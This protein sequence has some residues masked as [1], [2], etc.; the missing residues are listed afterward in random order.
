MLILNQWKVIVLFLYNHFFYCSVVNVSSL[1]GISGSP[2]LG[3]YCASK[4]AVEGMSKCVREELAH[5]SIHMSN[6]NPGFM[7]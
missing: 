5:W 7:R 4:H 1:A 3:A 6:V 2:A